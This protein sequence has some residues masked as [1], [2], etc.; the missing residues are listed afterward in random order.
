MLPLLREQ[1]A[2]AC[3]VQ[4]PYDDLKTLLQESGFKYDLSFVEQFSDVNSDNNYNN[5]DAWGFQVMTDDD[6][7]KELV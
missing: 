4:R 6:T 2:S 1:F 5:V 3:T 7:R